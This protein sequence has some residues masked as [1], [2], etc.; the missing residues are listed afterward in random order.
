MSATNTPRG[1][2]PPGGFSSIVFDD[3]QPAVTYTRLSYSKTADRSANTS[4]FDAAY[5]RPAKKSILH[6]KDSLKDL[7]VDASTASAPGTPTSGSRRKI[8]QAPG[9]NSSIKLV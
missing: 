3:S 9:G 8:S 6:H 7:L 1:K 2:V 5:M 4:D